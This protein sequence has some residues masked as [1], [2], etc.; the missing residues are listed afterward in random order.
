MRDNIPLHWS[1]NYNH[2]AQKPH[3]ANNLLNLLN[4]FKINSSIGDKCEGKNTYIKQVFE[5]LPNYWKGYNRTSET[6]TIGNLVIERNFENGQIWNYHVQYQN[7]TNGENIRFN[8]LCRSDIYRTLHESWQ[9]DIKNE[10]GDGYSKLLLNGTLISDDEIQLSI[11]DI[12]ISAGTVDNCIPLTC[13]W[14]MYDVIPTLANT[15]KHSGFSAQIALLEDLEH[16]RPK[17][18]IGYLG[19]I[20]Q[21]LPL[22]G[23]FL[24]GEGL[25][26]S[27]WWVDT[28]QTV[29]VSTVFETLVLKEITRGVS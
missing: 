23:Y 8:F 17:C 7:T 27:Y 16:L 10:S 5:I 1:F 20:E 18:N 9:V 21:P 26:P 14:A 12:E 4:D 19:S 13:N 2:G 3:F 15:E 24:Y 29:I 28:G 6:L 25:L 22:D 11:N